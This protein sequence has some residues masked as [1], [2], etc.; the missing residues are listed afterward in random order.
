MS[1]PVR[2]RF[3][4][5]RS[6]QHRAMERSLGETARKSSSDPRRAARGGE[7]EAQRARASA[8]GKALGRIGLASRAAVYLVL[9]YLAADIAAGGGQGT[10]A[11]SQGVLN[12]IGRQPAGSALLVLLACG[13][14]AYAGWRFLQAAAGDESEAGGTGAWKRLGWTGIGALYVAL[15]ARA[16]LVLA[17]PGSSNGG[18]S[19]AGGAFSASRTL[20]S[21]GG[22]ALLG[23]VGVGVAGGG[24][25]LAVWALRHDFTRRLDRRRMPAELLR[26]S[27]VVEVF[28]NVVRG[29]A[30]AGI[31]ASMLAAAVDGRASVAKGLNGLLH[32]LLAQP[33]G[34]ALLG[35]AAAGFVAFGLASL[36]ETVYQDVGPGRARGGR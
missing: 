5:R 4:Q 15:G 9:G 36:V 21:I 19:G 7:R 32:S 13:F 35:V 31:G 6:G 2:G 23:S 30:F 34:T 10:N 17:D 8:A 12:A 22:P 20:L 16:F 11:S 28:G 33:F 14:F 3:S 26:P 18:A 1:I 29:L 25:A 27:R 24:I